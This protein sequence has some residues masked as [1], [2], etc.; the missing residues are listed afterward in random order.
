MAKRRQLPKASPADSRPAD[1]TLADLAPIPADQ[2]VTPSKPG[3]VKS[4]SRQGIVE[5]SRRWLSNNKDAILAEC[6]ML[7]RTAT[8][9]D[10]VRVDLAKKL[11]DK[12]M[13]DITDHEKGSTG[14]AVQ[15]VING[16]PGRA[17]LVQ[18]SIDAEST[19]VE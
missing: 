9:E 3:A 17:Q 11:I 7:L 13:P 18:P 14:N 4:Y 12:L 2:E 8:N 6:F 10:R 15:I 5:Y 19:P 16:M 1:P